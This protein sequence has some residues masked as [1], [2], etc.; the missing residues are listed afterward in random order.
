M[1]LVTGAFWAGAPLLA[2]FSGHE[3][4]HSLAMIMLACGYFLVFTQFRNQ[5]MQALTVSSPYTAAT[6]VI[7]IQ[8]F[9]TPL[10]WPFMAAM[11][12]LWSVLAV[13]VML[14]ALMQEELT[15]AGESQAHLIEELAQAKDHAEAANRAKSAFL[16]TMSHEIRTPLNGV[17]GM[18]QAMAARRAAATAARAAGR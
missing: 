17:L 15:A 14:S 5:F 10:F 2:W 4:G 18:A 9:G 11:P 3:F 7:A 13:H 6:L 8:S 1:A 16:A 12:F